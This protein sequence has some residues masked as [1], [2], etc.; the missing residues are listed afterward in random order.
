[1]WGNHLFVFSINFSNRGKVETLTSEEQTYK[2][3]SDLSFNKVE[4][5]NFEGPQ[6]KKK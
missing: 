6:F 3:N 5:N 2:L 4:N 1:M